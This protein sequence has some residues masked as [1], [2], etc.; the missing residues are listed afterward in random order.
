MAGL[1]GE[2]AAGSRNLMRAR[3]K[4]DESAAGGL[5][6]RLRA[7]IASEGPLSVADYMAACLSDPDEGYYASRQPIG[8]SGDFITAP[9]ISQIFGELIGLWAAAVWQSMG[10]PR[11]IV[12]ELGPGRG[13]LMA[14][15]LRAWQSVPRFPQSISIAL[16]ETS[17]SLREVQQKTLRGSPVSLVWDETIEEIPQGPL[18]LIANEFLDALPIRQFVHRDGAWRERAITVT[19]NGAFAFTDGEPIASEALP[20]IARANDVPEGAILEICPEAEPLVAA[21]ARRA[22]NAPLAALFIDYGHTGSGFGDTLQAVSRHEYADPLALPGSVD[23][24]SHVDFAAIARLATAHGLDVHGPLPQGG[25]LLNLG[26]E[27]RRD[28]LLERAL[29]EQRE[30]IESGAKRLIDPRE[31][32]M[33]FKAIALTSK[34]LPAPPGFASAR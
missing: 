24:T 32:G 18:V 20:S 6:E 25:F 28:R 31:M 33:L 1:A 30:A 9:E 10:E 3:R 12:A 5:A 21:L 2:T 34:G 23:L 4:P 16:I 13:T 8:G 19:Q 11:G 15:A 17:P 29:P 22:K 7:R 14:D 27:L 26:L